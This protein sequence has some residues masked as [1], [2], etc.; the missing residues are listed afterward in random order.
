[1]KT[2]QILIAF[3]ILLFVQIKGKSQIKKNAGNHKSMNIVDQKPILSP[4]QNALLNR[5]FKHIDFI[6]INIAQLCQLAQSKR[7]DIPVSI[8][9]G[10]DVWNMVISENELRSPEYKCEITT[11][12]G[13]FEIPREACGTFAGYETSENESWVRMNIRPHSFSSV[14]HLEG[15]TYYLE[16]LK[17]FIQEADENWIMIYTQE[18]LMTS[19]AR[20]GGGTMLQEVEQ[21]IEQLKPKAMNKLNKN[22]KHSNSADEVKMTGKAP[23]NA[24]S[25]NYTEMMRSVQG[26]NCRKLEIVTESDYDNYNSSALYRVTF[27][28]MLDNL[29]NVE[30]LFLGQ[31]G[32]KFVI[33]Y[34]HEWTT[35]S[36][37]YTLENVCSGYD[38]RKQ[39]RDYW[40]NP[41]SY[42]YNNIVKDVGIFYSGVNFDGSTAGCAPVGGINDV[43]NGQLSS[44]QYMIVQT[45]L[46]DGIF[47]Y[48]WSAGHFLSLTGHELGHMFGANHNDSCPN[49]MTSSFDPFLLANNYWISS[50][51]TEINNKLGQNNTIER[52]STRYFILPVTA[53]LF[54]SMINGGEIFLKSSATSS[55][56]STFSFEGV[57]GCEVSG[58][59]TISASGLGG[60]T[61][62]TAACNNGG[63]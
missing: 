51:I 32:V 21:K 13:R 20:C 1:M 11:D 22:G 39:F 8:A 2:I 28:E 58:N 12:S 9:N 53:P 7:F 52:L 44:D 29:N 40:N 46:Y 33:R 49:I 41:S 48:N 42:F 55:S 10:A 30:P 43:F 60:I 47:V 14:I 34:Q 4:V 62:K 23:I 15:K 24:N 56:I 25:L 50:S 31:F 54:N 36:D 18:D 35:S 3:G 17:N 38:R 59:S 26:T 5:S 27:S 37:P 45:N 6:K 19:Q 63:Y 61:I 16:M 57:D